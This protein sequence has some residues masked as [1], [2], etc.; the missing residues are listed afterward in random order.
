MNEKKKSFWA[1]LFLVLGLAL[2]ILGIVWV[3]EIGILKSTQ[4]VLVSFPD[5][6]GLRTGDPVD[7][8]GVK[9][10][11]VAKLKLREYDVLVT[12]EIEKDVFLP[13]DSKIVMR[14]LSF[15]SG[16]KY[17][18]IELGRSKNP[19]NPEKLFKGS[20]YDEF[21]I[22]NLT[23]TLRRVNQVISKIDVESVSDAITKKIDEVFESSKKSL[24]V[25]GQHSSDIDSLITALHR[26]SGNL[27][28]LTTELKQGKGTLGKLLKEDKAYKEILSTNRELKAL[29][30]DIK[31][32]PERYFKIKVF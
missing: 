2:L 21:S 14:N 22:G 12:L 16:E 17:I 23:A 19:Y 10:G 31:A 9:K 27:D 4:K 20:Y 26:I 32:H 11:K 24:E 29:I 1:G 25:I 15:L 8:A 5:V 28:T 30:Q 13:E 18:K 7:I 3:K 6:G